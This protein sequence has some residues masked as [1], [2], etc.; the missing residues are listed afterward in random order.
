MATQSFR[1][2]HV[3]QKAHQLVLDIYKYTD[4]FPAKRHIVFFLNYEGREYQF[5]LILQKVSRK[6]AK[7]IKSVV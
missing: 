2:L 5:R 3:W 4:K 7:R 1:D 6:R